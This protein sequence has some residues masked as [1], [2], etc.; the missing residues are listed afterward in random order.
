MIKILVIGGGIGGPA[1]CLFCKKF[2]IEAEITLAEKTPEFKNI[3][4]A[5][6]LWGNG[7]KILD[8]LDLVKNID[9]KFGY[10][11]PW[12]V[13]ETTEHKILKSLYL[14]AFKKFGPTISIPRSALQLALVKAMEAQHITI[15]L[16][17]PVRIISNDSNGV[18]AQLGEGAPEHFDLVVAADG[19]KSATRDFLFGPGKLKNLDVAL[20]QFW[21][22][23]QFQHPRGLVDTVRSGRIIVRA[24]V[25]D[26]ACMLLL[27]KHHSP[28]IEPPE[29]R[30]EVLLKVF[31]D[32]NPEVLEIIKSIENPETIMRDNTAHIMLD[33]WYKDRVVLI[34]DAQHAVSP[35]TGM[36][37]SMALEDAYVLAQ[38]LQ[39]N[40]DTSQALAAFCQRRAPR[41]K[42]IK[43]FS[44]QLETWTLASGWRWYISKILLSIAPASIFTNEFMWF[45]SREI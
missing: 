23:E 27:A 20:W 40:P 30:K 13:I 31:S 3:G 43:Q 37:A 38:E 8:Q 4:F 17:S 39:K 42:K 33:E 21:V 25:G 29:K 24:P 15:R 34:G 26:R 10:E 9:D 5:I 35:A 36:G 2:G 41:I 32:F 11:I 6:S 7:R 44:H 16:N 28:E 1:F 14:N 19:I 18:V 22:P 45:L 12:N